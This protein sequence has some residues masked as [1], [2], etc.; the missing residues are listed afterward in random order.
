MLRE[1]WKKTSE[2][3]YP[4]KHDLVCIA[5]VSVGEREKVNRIGII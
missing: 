4:R 3:N 5:E 2:S 1:V